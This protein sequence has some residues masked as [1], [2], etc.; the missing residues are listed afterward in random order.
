MAMLS[1]V[2][3]NEKPDAKWIEGKWVQT[4]RTEEEDEKQKVKL[5]L[6]LEEMQVV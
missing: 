4:I 1:S 3:Q 5:F 6:I 2:L